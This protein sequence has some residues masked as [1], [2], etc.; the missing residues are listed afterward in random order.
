MKSKY[1]KLLKVALIAV[2]C[3]ACVVTKHTTTSIGGKKAPALTMQLQQ[4]QSQ[5]KLVDKELQKLYSEKPFSRLS[6]LKKIQESAKKQIGRKKTIRWDQLI[7]QQKKEKNHLSLKS[8]LALAKLKLK[9]TKKRQQHMDAQQLDAPL[10]DIF[11]QLNQRYQQNKEKL[12]VENFQ[13][14]QKL[15]QIQLQKRLDLKSRFSVD[16]SKKEQQMSQQYSQTLKDTI[17]QLGTIDRK[18]IFEQLKQELHLIRRK[19]ELKLKNFQIKL[20][21]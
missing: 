2:F 15:A 11:A 7:Q 19:D 4:V 20:I 8:K 14:E 9:Y 1:Q 18:K 12:S 21:Q 10:G 6:N 16:L 5:I 17:Q 13:K 3:L